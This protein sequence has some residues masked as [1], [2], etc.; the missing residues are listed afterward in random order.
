MSEIDTKVGLSLPKDLD[1]D[2]SVS[3]LIL[4]NNLLYNL[5]SFT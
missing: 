5:Y 3:R 2:D 4:F 1:I